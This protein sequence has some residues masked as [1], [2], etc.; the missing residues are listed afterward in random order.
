MRKEVILG[1]SLGGSMLA[2]VIIY[3]TATSGNNRDAHPVDTGGQVAEVGAGGSGDAPGQSG[4][5]SATTGGEYKPIDSAFTSKTGK[6][7]ENSKSQLLVATVTEKTDPVWGPRLWA[8]TAVSVTPDPTNNSGAPL[9]SNIP[10]TGGDQSSVAD[11]G[12]IAHTPPTQGATGVQDRVDVPRP[13]TPMVPRATPGKSHTHK[14]MKGETFSTI[15]A[16]A[17]G[18]PNLYAYILRANPKL[19]PTKLKPGIEINLPDISEVRG[20]EKSVDKD[21]EKSTTAGA[22]THRIEPALDAKTEYRVQSGDS[23]HKI[24]VKLYG[25]IDMVPKIYEMNKSAIGDNPA[26]LKLG[27]VLKLPQAP[28]AAAAA[29]TN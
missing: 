3:L 7:R 20:P 25:K 26:K 28:S 6:P 23:L 21:S 12:N 18:S 15:A 29:S 1:M 11:V 5:G 10:Q 24:A 2:M 22:I 9:D 19:D 16:A 13:A 4:D 14:L 17:Y 8:D 27:M